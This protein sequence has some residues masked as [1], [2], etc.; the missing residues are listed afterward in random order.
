MK[1]VNPTSEQAEKFAHSVPDDKPIVML[2]LLKFRDVAD[3]GAS[4]PRGLTGKEAYLRYS[5]AVLPLM[6]EVG[7]Q[8][9]WMGN[10]RANLIAPE[11]ESW[12][13]VVL[14][15]YP[16]RAAFLRMVRSAA[17]QAVSHHRTAAL[18]DSR[19][20]ETTAAFLP[21]F[22]FRAARRVVQVK[23]LLFPEIPR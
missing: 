18:E 17:Y 14:A 10:A 4:G 12:D 15:H 1:T 9:L 22:L 13:Q 7:G 2:N 20:I 21:R 19:L 5:K 6:F 16:S 3:Y 11:G 8:P 23:S